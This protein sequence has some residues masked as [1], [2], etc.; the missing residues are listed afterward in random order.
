[1]KHEKH[2]KHGSK[3]PDLEEIRENHS[4]SSGLFFK[5]RRQLYSEF[6]PFQKIEVFEND[7]FGNILFLDGLVQTTE[8]DEYFYHEML[9]HPAC[10]SH[11]GPEKCLIIGGGDGGTLKEVLR[12]PL[13]KVWFVE[14]DRRVIEV[15]QKYFPWLNEALKDER[16][17]LVIADGNE[18]IKTTDEKFD[19]VLID[20][21][22]PVGPSAVLDGRQFYG[23]LK[24]CLNPGGVLVAQAGSPV[25]HFEY[26]KQKALL[27]K[28]IYTNVYFFYGPVPTYPG[29]NWCY[30]FL[31]ENRLPWGKK[32]SPPAG[33]K[34]YTPDIH[35]AAFSL[36]GF[37][38]DL[39][40]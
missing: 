16:T 8:K 33:L 2:G 24:Q 7:F 37:L 17:E 23:K 11:P 12:Y 19:V 13:K 28:D 21:S 35:K 31:S 30:V 20:S 34:Y 38:K 9:A 22:E 14:I 3:N 4:P 39:S 6:S 10:V 5:V 27:L 15:C 32:Q 26:L 1:M 36:P 25:F 18:F 29:G 40:G